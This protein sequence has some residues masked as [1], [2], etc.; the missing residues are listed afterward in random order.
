MM[1]EIASLKQELQRDELISSGPQEIL[2]S[3]CHSLPHLT[4]F[5]RNL[6]IAYPVSGSGP[7]RSEKEM[8]IHIDK[9]RGLVSY[10]TWP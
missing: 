8:E 1:G 4:H 6:C 9:D 7:Q 3:F 10:N 5:T 2:E